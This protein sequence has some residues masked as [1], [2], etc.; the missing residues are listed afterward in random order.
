[1]YFTIEHLATVHFATV[2]LALYTLT[3][4]LLGLYLMYTECAKGLNGAWLKI[5]CKLIPCQGFFLVTSRHA[6]VDRRSHPFALFSISRFG[7]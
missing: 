5:S 1:M 3:L 4:I 7:M 2:C 6:R